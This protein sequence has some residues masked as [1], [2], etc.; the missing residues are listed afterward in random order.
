MNVLRK[1]VDALTPGGIGLDLQVIRPHPQVESDGRVLF[2][3]DGSPLF[4]DADAARTAVD[5]LISEGRLIEEAVDEHDVL[6]HY[7]NGAEV[8]DQWAPGRRKLSAD[9]V[10]LLRGVER[11]C[12]IRERCLLRRLRRES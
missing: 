1:M 8:V 10:E 5:L 7:A 2:V 11:E 9:R 12:V 4:A 6:R 3:A